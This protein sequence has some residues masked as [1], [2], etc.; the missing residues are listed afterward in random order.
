MQ[1][2]ATPIFSLNVLKLGYKIIF[3][4]CVGCRFQ[5]NE[6]L[7]NF[8]NTIACPSW[9]N[10]DTSDQFLKI[11]WKRIKSYGKTNSTEYYLLILHEVTLLLAKTDSSSGIVAR[12]MKSLNHLS[13]MYAT[14]SVQVPHGIR[15]VLG[16]GLHFLQNLSLFDVYGKT[17]FHIIHNIINISFFFRKLS[18][19]PYNHVIEA[20][21]VIIFL[22]V[23]V[24]MQRH[25]K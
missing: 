14:S 22:K 15:Q 10:P 17:F 20:G 2:F 12:K 11:F 9:S 4:N 6:L 7:R 18:A 24:C 16:R 21:H 19:E 25:Q 23:C 1:F 8:W 13:W 5:V 3:Y